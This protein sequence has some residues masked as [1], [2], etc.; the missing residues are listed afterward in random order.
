M[1][2]VDEIRA[3]AERIVKQCEG[4]PGQEIE[5]LAKALLALQMEVEELQAII[6]EFAKCATESMLPR[7]R[8]VQV[9]H[10][11]WEALQQAALSAPPRAPTQPQT[12]E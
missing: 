9:D 6:V 8:T 10:D 2:T 3:M 1:T 11:T 4:A 5:T 12:G 7:Y